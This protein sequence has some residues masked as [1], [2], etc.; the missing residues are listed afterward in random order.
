MRK[1]CFG[2]AL[3]L[4]ALPAKAQDAAK[5]A[6][7]Y[8]DIHMERNVD[9]PAQLV[10]SRVGGYCQIEA[11]FGTKCVY[12]SGNGD[13][14]TNRQL[15]GT[16]NELMVAKTPLSY[17]YAQPTSPI[18]YHGNLSVEVVD[19]GHS[20]IVYDLL[21]DAASMTPDA[22]AADMAKRKQRF[23]AGI[24]KMVQIADAP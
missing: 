9:R 4:A 11:W 12:T 14:G 24:D 13:I 10:W 20:K 21:Y 8:V 19:S 7:D 22:K 16:T 3:A 18:F 1:I 2:L 5:P 23:E 6:P 15:N 17:A